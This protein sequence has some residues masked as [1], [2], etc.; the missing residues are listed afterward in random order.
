MVVV[1]MVVLSAFNLL[2]YVSC[3]FGKNKLKSKQNK[4]EL[5]EKL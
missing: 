1:A 2:G 3:T 5:V 4:Q